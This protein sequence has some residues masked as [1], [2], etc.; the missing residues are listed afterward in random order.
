MFG[1]KN[2]E[3]GA[4]AYDACDAERGIGYYAEARAVA[5]GGKTVRRGGV[6][7]LKA[8]IATLYFN[9]RTSFNGW[10]KHPVLEGKPYTEPCR[11]ELDA[12]AAKGYETL[13]AAHIADHRA[14]YD[15]VSLDLGGG[16][17]ATL[18]TD[19][20]LYAHENGGDDPALYAL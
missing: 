9:V 11:A 2:E 5:E 16:E 10:D 19:E 20:R 3:R 17:E 4:I 6:R 13:K 12:A 8:D 7:V 18:P 1:A 15:R 14:L